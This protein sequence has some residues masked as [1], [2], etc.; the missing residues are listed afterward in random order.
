MNTPQESTQGKG[1]L[2][3]KGKPIVRKILVQAAWVA[4][5]HDKELQAIYER[6]AAKSGAKRAIVAVARRLIGRIRACFRTG[7]IYEAQKVER[8]T[9]KFKKLA[10]NQKAKRFKKQISCLK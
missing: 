2:Q 10:T 4:I 9:L 6:I 5:R 7:E 3:N 8:P 1:I